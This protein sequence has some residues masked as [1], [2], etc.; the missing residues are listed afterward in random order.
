MR[1]TT[2]YILRF[3]IRGCI[4][5]YRITKEVKD[6][7]KMIWSENTGDMVYKG[8]T[9][10]GKHYTWAEADELYYRDE[11]DDTY[12]MEIPKEADLD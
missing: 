10:K 8:F 1:N 11:V 9:Y 5:P 4:S 7:A 6:M 12:L 3:W 2:L